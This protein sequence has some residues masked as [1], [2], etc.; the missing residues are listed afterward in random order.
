MCNGSFKITKGGSFRGNHSR[1][2]KFHHRQLGSLFHLGTVVPVSR[3][4]VLKS[5][6]RKV[7]ASR[8]GAM[9]AAKEFSIKI[10]VFELLLY[11]TH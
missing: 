11:L 2:P 6:P 1:N 3:S 8:P 10:A 5:F 7:T 4:W 9:T